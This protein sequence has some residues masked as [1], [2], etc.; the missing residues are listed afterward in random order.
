MN[1]YTAVVTAYN[2]EDTILDS[3][4]SIRKQSIKPQEIILIDDNSIDFTLEKVNSFKSSLP[5][6]RVIVN[7]INRGQSFSRNIACNL[8]RTKF[9][10]FFDSDDVSIPTRASLHLHHFSKGSAISFVSS[11]K[12]YP[13]G[14][15]V[16]HINSNLTEIPDLNLFVNLL[17]LGKK[18]GKSSD[19]YIP[20]STCAVSV[21]HFKQVSGFD[22]SLRRLED[23]DLAI[24]FARF[25]YQFAWSAEVGVIRRHS[26]SES[27]G[28]GIDMRFEKDLLIKY[29][30]ILGERNFRNSL[31]HMRT[32]QLFFAR[33]YYLLIFHLIRHP[34]YCF[35]SL[36]KS[37]RLLNRLTHE[38]RMSI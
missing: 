8:A 12:R 1:E 20:A 37:K 32:R 25:S 24:K 23:V 31:I 29:R 16:R 11:V 7:S 26:E 22:E 15:E 38:I 19:I 36:R 9:L 21:P 4:E 33:N 34:L 6:L 27:K 17:L 14:Y 2:S 30:D 3:L 18:S 28:R 13:S 5:S 35:K 10:I